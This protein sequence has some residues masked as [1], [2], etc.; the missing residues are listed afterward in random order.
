M[1]QITCATLSVLIAAAFACSPRDRQETANRTEAAAQ[2]V[3]DAAREGADEVRDEARDARDY[4][5]AQRNDF[6]RDIDAR[7]EGLDREIAELER[8]AKR[9]ADKTR[10]SAL[11]NIRL[12]RKAV[13]R[14]MDRLGSA[15]ESSWDDLKR[16]INQSVYSLEEA[17]RRTRPDA[18]PMGGTGPS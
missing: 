14:D 11:A 9:G 1:R 16:A 5:F 6:R 12:A 7:V 2:D 18:R 15:T 10:D 13:K 17:V 8:D 3:G 4:A